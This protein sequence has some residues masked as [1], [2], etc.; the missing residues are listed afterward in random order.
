MISSKI[1]SLM[2]QDDRYPTND[3]EAL[4]WSLLLQVLATKELNRKC[5]P[6][7]GRRGKLN[8]IDRVQLGVHE[9][10]KKIVEMTPQFPKMHEYYFDILQTAEGPEGSI[11]FSRMTEPDETDEYHNTVFP[12]AVQ[13]L[14]TSHLGVTDYG[15][16]DIMWKKNSPVEP[17]TVFSK[18]D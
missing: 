5:P 15:T 18:R 10:R 16:Y 4:V 7:L 12:D 17:G 3:L 1:E 8:Q 2:Q 9:V 11:N 14:I 6:G 13:M